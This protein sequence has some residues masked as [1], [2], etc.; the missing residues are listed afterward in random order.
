M[1][2]SSSKNVVQ[3]AIQ[4]SALLGAAPLSV[5]PIIG[6]SLDGAWS[7]EGYGYAFNVRDGEWTY[8]RAENPVL[9]RKN[10]A[11]GSVEKNIDRSTRRFS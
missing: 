2:S 7:S 5:A 3:C 9:C 1:T 10:A 8:L 6:Q 11:P 4:I